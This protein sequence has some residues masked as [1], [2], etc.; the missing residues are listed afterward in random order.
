MRWTFPVALD[1]AEATP[2]FVQIARAISGDVERGRLRTGD[3][4]PGSRT[5]ADTLGVNRN[6]VVAAYAE[7]AAQ[8]WVEPR[9][10][11]ATVVLPQVSSPTRPGTTRAA[12]RLGFDVKPLAPPRNFPRARYTLAGGV[13]DLRLVPIDALARAYR[14]AA[15]AYG[16]SV[17][18][19]TD[20]A[21][22]HP[23]L[24]AALAD[25]LSKTRGL[26]VG[27]DSI[28]VTRGSQMAIDLVARAILARGD[29]VAVENPGY[30]PA[31]GALE[32]AGAKLVPV[33]VDRD[34]LV[35][36]RV[37]A[38]R[39]LY[40]T[41]HHQFPTTATLS[42][43]RRLALL[44]LASERRMAIVEDDYDYEF[45]YEGRPILPLASSDRHGVVVY[46]GTL[47]KILA[48]GLRL[49]FVVAPEPFVALLARERMFLDRQGDHVLELAIAEL[50]EDGE[51][52]R[53]A[54]RMR[55]MYQ[56]RRDV[57]VAALAKHVGSAL[58]FE[59]PRGGMSIWAESAVNVERW[60][61][62]AL[63]EG[64]SFQTGRSFT[65]DGKGIP[66]ARLG[67]ASF[68]DRAL[69]DVAKRLGKTRPREPT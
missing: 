52:T 41:P 51:L 49:G 68:N 44:H 5:L 60:R 45:H 1:D 31:W 4:L 42:P 30:T 8:G 46:I 39:A 21:R 37:P 67:F 23:R 36:A 10:R 53:H 58:S 12:T 24:R 7:L 16:T 47:S 3:A 17:L 43:A 14:R 48:P 63:V 66:F 38:A 57:F 19:Y 50:M 29:R 59:V 40:V 28:L 9:P 13:P 62:R 34:G 65:F 33:P 55:R 2:L 61:E 20:D 6:T 27:P 54:R 25:M 32:R 15:R 18:G 22:G 35:V 56:A 26:A 69:E 11:G 64:V